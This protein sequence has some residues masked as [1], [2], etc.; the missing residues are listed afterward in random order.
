MKNIIYFLV[1]LSVAIATAFIL[2]HWLEQYNDPGYVIIG[3]G[4]WSLETSLV[5]FTVGLIILFFVLYVF[6]R[7]LG[8]L[9][10]L[11]G[12][13]QDKRRNIKFNRSQDALISGLVDSAEGNWQKAEKVLI[14]H[15]S[16]SGAPLIHYLTAARAAQSRGAFKKRDEYLEIAK[17]Q[18]PGSEVVVGLTQAELH[19]SEKQFDHAL[20]AL[21]QVHSIDPTHASVLKLLHQTY[22]HL[23]DWE[24]IRKLI[25]SLHQ[26]KVMMEAEVKLLEAETFSQLLKQAAEEGNANETQALWSNIPKH[27]QSMH[28]IRA[29]YFAAMIEAG[30][31][32]S[33]GDDMVNAI[34]E[35][36]DETLL[37]L[38]GNVQSRDYPAQLE[39]AEKWLVQH[40]GDVVLLRVL[41]KISIKCSEMERAEKYL[42]KSISIEPTVA[43]Y[44]ML[45]ELLNEKGEKDKASECFK[46]GL[47]LASSEVVT[48]VETI[49][50]DSE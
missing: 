24:A 16:N 38:Y 35:R 15:A 11:P 36:W 3:F 17:E 22:K 42:S 14:K 2:R 13:M 10:R 20:E 33:I 5:V 48:S 26:H 43:A 32:A 31:G 23:G 19:L 8:W 18:S 25:P 12:Q 39:T 7:L 1:S 45:G 28:G 6:F 4:H 29:I 49:S 50:S 46:R 41:G 27:I 9:I 40:P 21:T 37:V 34:T 47:E 30:A 44:Q